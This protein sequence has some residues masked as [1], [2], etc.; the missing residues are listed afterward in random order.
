VR[1]QPL[2]T[3]GRLLN[4]EPGRVLD[5]YLIVE[6]LRPDGLADLYDAHDRR[7]GSAVALRVL[8]EDLLADRAARRAFRRADRITRPLNHPGIVRRLRHDRRPSR[9]YLVFED[10]EGTRLRDWLRDFAGAPLSL[11][12]PWCQELAETLEYLHR[13]GIVHGDVRPENVLVTAD[14]HLKLDGF[15]RATRRSLPGRAKA[16]P[17][18]ETSGYSSPEHLQ[19]RR[20]DDRADLYAWGVLTYELLCGRPPFTGAT[21]IARMLAQLHDV[22]TQPRALRPEIDQ[23]LNAV[24]LRAMRRRPES[25]YQSTRNLTADLKRLATLDPGDFDLSPDP[26]LTGLA[27]LGQTRRL[28]PTAAAATIGLWAILAFSIGLASLVR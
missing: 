5:D 26:P 11:A 1:N 7:S 3:A 9:P 12:V 6:V 14:L 25:R 10:V 13:R 22:P 8:K 24:V 28:W 18:L 27:V 20:T 17:S 15:D 23:S 4:L 19:G 16:H 21:P 2:L